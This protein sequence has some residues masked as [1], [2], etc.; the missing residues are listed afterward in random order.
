MSG[1]DHHFHGL[2]ILERPFCRWES[3]KMAGFNPNLA[4][5]REEVAPHLPHHRP[6]RH[7]PA[8]KEWENLIN[9]WSFLLR[10]ANFYE[11]LNVRIFRF[12]CH[13][14]H[15]G[16]AHFLKPIFG[17]YGFQEYSRDMFAI[18]S[19]LL[20]FLP[21]RL[22]Y[23]GRLGRSTFNYPSILPSPKYRRRYPLLYP[24]PCK[25]VPQR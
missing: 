3:P 8:M 17:F 10:V 14:S 12:R 22:G 19:A 23:L 6:L 13:I 16:A 2:S 7:P 15:F 11:E 25:L 5:L 20:R 24:V 18:P 4:K 21:S 9:L 1:L